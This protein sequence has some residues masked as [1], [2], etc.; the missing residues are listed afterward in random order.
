MSKIT[1]VIIRSLHGGVQIFVFFDNGYGASVVQHKWSYG[2][3]EG[4]FEIAVLKGDK[5]NS[6]ICYDTDIT[7]D[8]LG[9]QDNKD[10]ENVL[11]R[12]SELENAE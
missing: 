10:V 1:D 4:L 11:K 6:C 12:I 2:G 3:Q 9:Y 8:V 5:N 7:D